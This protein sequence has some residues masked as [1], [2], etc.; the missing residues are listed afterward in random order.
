[1]LAKV[2][3][4][5]KIPN[6]LFPGCRYGLSK[7]DIADAEKQLAELELKMAELA[8]AKPS[9]AQHTL[10]QLLGELTSI[11]TFE[12]GLKWFSMV[13]SLMF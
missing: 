13:S 8:Q 11:L 2:D 9:S 7:E 12:T 5:R 4:L 6:K 10:L 1:M 3:L